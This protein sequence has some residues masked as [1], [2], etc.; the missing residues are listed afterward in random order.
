ME[1][2]QF[3]RLLS[4]FAVVRSADFV[5]TSIPLPIQRPKAH[6]TPPRALTHAR[7]VGEDAGDFA[8]NLQL[9]LEAELDHSRASVVAAEVHR[10]LEGFFDAC[11]L[12]HL[13]ALA[14]LLGTDQDKQV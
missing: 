6:T 4:R 1:D 14:K 13:E 8:D 12:D 11:S 5:D 9:V 2:D 10:N 3:E 7:Q